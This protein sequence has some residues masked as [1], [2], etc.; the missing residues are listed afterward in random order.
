MSRPIEID[1]VANVAKALSGMKDVE[2]SLDDVAAALVA[3]SNDAPDL[4]RKLAKAMQGAE[5]DVESLER[6][7]KEV[8]KATDQAADKAVRDFD[9]VGD[10]ADEA[11]RE[12]GDEFKQNL[13]ESLASGDIEDLLSD[14]LGG[15]VAGL[16]GPVGL[17]AAAFA[18]IAAVAFNEARKQAE[19]VKVFAEAWASSIESLFTQ[20]VARATKLEQLEAFN[21]FL[22]ESAE[23]I[24]GMG[25]AFRDAG[26]DQQAFLISAFEG[27]DALQRQRDA[28]MEIVEQ[29]SRVVVTATG[30][31][32][33]RTQ[34]AKAAADLIGYLDGVAGK[35]G[36]ISDELG[37]QATAS[38][39]YAQQLGLVDTNLDGVI[40][41]LDKAA[42]NSAAIEG[43]LKRIP[44][45]LDDINSRR[46]NE[47]TLTVRVYGVDRGN[48]PIQ[49]PG[50]ALLS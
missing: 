31:V 25:G 36:E 43:N 24:R 16:K 14:T 21:T 7:I 5:K 20:G 11:G 39:A 37:T 4:E 6:A 2:I 17:A 29:G 19:E 30:A 34:E 42:Q 22:K 46:L 49:L 15:L 48:R 44:G 26:V 8:P 41:G 13:G 18:G 23:Q 3:A 32:E 10:S 9:R 45:V 12:V 28:L 40:D 1:F 27:G 38:Q 47:K 35:Q 50:T 33:I